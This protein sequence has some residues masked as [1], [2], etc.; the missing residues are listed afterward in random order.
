MSDLDKIVERDRSMD[1]SNKDAKEGTE[2]R[3]RINADRAAIKTRD[4]PEN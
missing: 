3:K 2:E 4:G 1:M